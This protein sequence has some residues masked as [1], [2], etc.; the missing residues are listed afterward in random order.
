[1]SDNTR[2]DLHDDPGHDDP[3]LDDE[4]TAPRRPVILYVLGALLALGLLAGIGA[5]GQ[6]GGAGWFGHR[7]I[8]YGTGELYILNMGDSP[9]LVSVD[10]RDRVE[11]DAENARLV[12]IIG[13]T[14]RV[15]VFDPDGTLIDT[16]SVT[17]DDSHALLNL[18]PESCLVVADISAFYG[19]QGQQLTFVD[20]L[21][22][23]QRV[24]VPDSRN[25]VWPRRDFPPRLDPTRGPGRWIELVACALFDEPEYLEAYMNVR[26]EQRMERRNAASPRE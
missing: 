3:R 12:E 9:R 22:P 4:P 15:E 16:Y 8:L 1:M 11:V 14:S 2:P 21:R 19:G 24:Y 18:S 26:L 13:G 25:I 23:D 5:I 6:L 7:Q 17:V 20:M 10:G